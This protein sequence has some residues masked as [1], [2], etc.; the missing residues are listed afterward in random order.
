VPPPL[1][2]RVRR[3][4]AQVAQ[5]RRAALSGW[6]LTVHPGVQSETRQ[7]HLDS[8]LSSK[9]QPNLPFTYN[10]PNTPRSTCPV[11]RQL[12]WAGGDTDEG[13]EG[14]ERL[15]AERRQ[16][17]RERRERRSRR[18]RRGSADGGGA[19]VAA[20][21]PATPAATAAGPGDAAA[22][23]LGASPGGRSSPSRLGAAWLT[24]LRMA[25][26]RTPS[27]AADLPTAAPPAER[28]Q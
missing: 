1:P 20:A 26:A 11:C 4:V 5:V 7:T 8:G 28:R 12:L 14:H 9:S 15:V 23:A 18:L 22:A 19:A 25:V 24:G 27:P 21:T 3:H 13:S 10:Q 2:R 6:V 16:Q 17:R